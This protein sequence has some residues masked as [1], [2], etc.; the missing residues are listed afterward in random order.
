MRCPSGHPVPA[1]A[2]R[3][4][5]LA[6]RFALF[7]S[8]LRALAR[9]TGAVL[10]DLEAVPTIGD[11]SL[12]ADDAVHLNPRGHRTLAY[13]AAA[14]LGVP[15]AGPL[16]RLEESLHADEEDELLAPSRAAWLRRHAMPWVLRRLR[17]R[18]AG[19]GRG[20]KHSDLV[21][22]GGRSGTRIDT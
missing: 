20:P 9:T 18:T 19:D 12:W 6:K 17:G 15:D 10:L 4:L 5:L 11:L 16:G 2:A 1:A 13:E 21:T 14:R 3:P 8:E 22:I 7:N